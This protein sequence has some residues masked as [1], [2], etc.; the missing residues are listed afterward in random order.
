MARSK[1]LH[2]IIWIVAPL[3]A[4][5]WRQRIA[6]NAARATQCFVW[7]RKVV[8]PS[9]IMAHMELTWTPQS[10]HVTSKP[11]TVAK[12]NGSG[13]ARRGLIH[14]G[15]S[16]QSDLRFFYKDSWLLRSVKPRQA[17]MYSQ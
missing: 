15:K 12:K 9:F 5:W 13:I 7:E 16:N 4:G 1:L 14:Q 2:R 6:T 10:M 3:R 17:D 8:Q 11:A